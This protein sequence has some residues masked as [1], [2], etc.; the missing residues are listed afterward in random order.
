MTHN[1]A[2]HFSRLLAF[3]LT[4]VMLLTVCFTPALADIRDQLSLNILWTD[5]NGRTQAVPAMP[6]P[7]STE[8]AYWVNLDAR[9]LGQ[10]LTVEAFAGDPA[11]SFYLLDEWGN[12]STAFVWQPEM[13]AM[14]TGFEYAHMLYY[15]VND[16]QADMPILL[17][18]SSMPLPEDAPEFQPYPVQVPVYYITQDGQ[19]LDTQYVECW[20]GE[21]TPIW[22]ASAY[23][24]GY[25]LQGSDSVNVRV[26]ES[27]NATPGEVTFTY[28]QIATP[29]PE[30]TDVPT[31]TPVAEVSVPVVYYHLN[32]TQL[33][34]QEIYLAPGTHTIQAN[35]GRTDGYMPVGDQVITITVYPDGSTDMASVVFYYDD[36]A[37]AEAVIPVYYYHEDGD[38]LDL[39]EV[40]LGEGNHIIRPN[41]SKVEGLELTG[42]DFAEV[43]VYGD[44]S[45]SVSY[46]AFTYKTPYVA[47]AEAVI[48]VYYYHEDGDLLD[49]QEVTLG[50]GNHIIRPN[51]SK[52]E[53]LELTGD[54]FAEVNVYGD[55]SA[56]V[57]YVA[58][59]YKTPYVAPAEAVIPV[60]YYNETGDLLDL[61][62]VTL[63]EGN[64]IIRPNSSKVEGL[65]LT[66]DDFAE[67]TVYG[68]GS[69]SVSYAV[70]VYA[71]PGAEQVEATLTIAYYHVDKGL[72]DTQTV[73]LPAGI[74]LIEANS[75]LTG[76]Y[77]PVGNTSVEV[78]VNADGSVQPA[79]VDFYY[80]D[81]YVAPVT[82]ELT[83]LYLLAD[84]TVINHDNLTLTPGTHTIQP[85]V[86]KIGGLELAGEQS[87]IVMVNEQGVISPEAVT[88][89]VR[90][91]AV[92]VTVHYQDDRGRDVAPTQVHTFE[93]DGVYTIQA[94]PEGL[95]YSYELAPGMQTQVDITVDG[96]VASQTDVYFYYQQ[97]QMVSTM[98]KVTVRY[99][100]TLGNEISS[101]Q[102]VSLMP[103]KHPLNA[104][105][106]DLP[107]GYELVSDAAIDVEVFENGTFTP[108]EVAF[109]YRVAEG[110]KATVTVY[111]RDDRGNDVATPVT[112][113]LGNGTYTIKAEPTDLAAGYVIFA[114][115]EDSAE[116]TVRNGVPT[117]KQVVFYYQK[118]VTEPTVFTLPVNY[119]DT[120]GRRI[121]TTQYVQ[122][123]AG[124]YAIQANPE[125]LPEGYELMMEAIQNIQVFQD[126]TTEPEEIAF[127]Y[128]APKKM[129]TIIVSYVDHQSQNI[130]DPFTME[131]DAGYHSISADPARVPNGYDVTSAEPVQVY[132]SREGEANPAQV[133]LSFAR[134][135]VETPIPVGELVY[136]YANVN[137]NSVAFRSE[138]TTTGGNKTVIKR[139]N[140]NTKVYVLQESYNDK[141]EV[142]AM[143]NVDG[144]TGYMMSK[145]L[146]IMTQQK[147]DAYAA[148][149]T[150]VP[151]FTPAP[152][153]TEVPTPTP[154]ATPTEIPTEVPTVTPTRPPVEAITPPPAETPTLEPLPSETATATPTASPT[155]TPAPY[156][157]YALTTR[158]T[159]LRTGVSS[160]EMT[161]IQNLEANELI[162]VINQVP[163][164]VSG[165]IWSI[166]STLKGQP[167][168]VQDSA[169]RYISDKEAE[170]YL[171]LWEMQNASPAPTEYVS[172]TPEPMQVEGYGV[173]L[174]DGVPFR[175]MQSE[176]S[177]IIDN[178][179]AGTV[180]FISGQTP[181]DG[182]YWHSVFYNNRWGYIRT[183][184]VRMM[185]VT[186]EEDYIESQHATPTPAT[187]NLP[188]DEYGMSSY[189]YVDCSDNSSVNWREAPSKNAKK[190]GA[191]KRY[192]FCLVR[193]TEYV[194]G[195]TWYEVSY[196]GVTGYLHGDFFRQMTIS[197]LEDFL[198]SEEY[199][200]GVANNSTSGDSAMDNVGV[201]GPG[202]IVSPEDQWVNQNPDVYVSFAPFNPI[203]TIAPIQTTPTLEPL[204]GVTA[205]PTA[206]PSPTPTFNPLPDVT[207]PTND[208]GEGGNSAL[209]VVVI[210]LLLLAVGGVFAL[211][212]YQQNRRRIAMRA[213]QRRA[214]AARAQQQQRPYAR[215][216][217]PGQ[218]RTGVYPNQQPTARR[219]VTNG[220]QPQSTSQYKPYSD[221]G[222]DAASYYRPAD[223]APVQPSATASVQ[224]E[225]PTQRTPRVGRRTAYRQAQEAANQAKNNE[226]PLDM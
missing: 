63:G 83:V 50:E 198:G 195:V 35:S 69:A 188:F 166:V 96:G 205:T 123:A 66:G 159:A 95:D 120:E 215:T 191:L 82:A 202:G 217:A 27:G 91:A 178:L 51:S 220:T 143:V 104:S 161:V 218:P 168:F 107:A 160:S 153:P 192:A 34:F 132:V 8:P 180:V 152:T 182:Q 212:R 151:T 129:A 85:D 94:A 199:L 33:D 133:T 86:T 179:S 171:A 100:D 76:G 77:V 177:R 5:N 196:N 93:E 98:A 75:A 130:I 57:S 150:P 142:W 80:E 46:V 7:D 185:T 213:A 155:A 197:E 184:L 30:P 78:T 53:G 173:V 209:W 72:L 62:E 17:Y 147:S 128:K 54:D 145:F 105:P 112:L 65:E 222:Y 163:D 36:A 59:T 99:F 110:P 174:G 23:T 158:V 97:R 146:D 39:Q 47:P 108:Q 67:V 24:D 117:Q 92:N 73:T 204:P 55:G 113:S 2:T 206:S 14:A 11:Y 211:V 225:E 186:E 134:Q 139:V 19:L 210:G 28:V 89:I 194:D 41:S 189:G 44:G 22:A 25:A 224:E 79:T 74:H 1:G 208:N 226:N 56:S 49:L 126:G 37:P 6:V 42:D 125:D 4:V 172:P 71:V 165:E 102:T 183:D 81:A 137:D 9:A 26:D 124:N 144:R 216:A 131:L 43:T 45:A 118:A 203:A 167:G 176:F 138:P 122:V 58:F 20:A 200:Q 40:T 10:L 84:G 88:F 162:N 154:T 52:V 135:V 136:R 221:A 3:A 119:Y 115:T 175:Q 148:G 70:F 190:V 170:P 106:T 15:A 169:L 48:P 111:Y 90:Q 149:S 157:G 164:P 127:Y 141:N 181:G 201:T 87:Q 29:T 60:Y 64:H 140:R 121:A 156:S 116:V 12:R 207:Y 21:T 32:G 103:G 61:Q 31:P 109:Y 38:L 68:D 114:G 214:Q 223:S 18:V 16:V 219:P 101:A 193:G 187:T 13:D